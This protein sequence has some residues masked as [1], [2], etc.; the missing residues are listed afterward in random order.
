MPRTK[1]DPKEIIRH[2]KAS[3]LKDVL[4]ESKESGITIHDLRDF[5]YAE[6]DKLGFDVNDGK[7]ESTK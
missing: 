2:S 4:D 3:V 6:L 1:L 5:I 7:L